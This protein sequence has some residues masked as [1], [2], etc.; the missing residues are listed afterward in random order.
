MH[1]LLH[2]LAKKPITQEEDAINTNTE[3]IKLTQRERERDYP[4]SSL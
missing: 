2:K 4:T 1:T 3:P